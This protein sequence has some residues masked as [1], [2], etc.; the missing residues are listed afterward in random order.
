MDPA[1]RGAAVPKRGHGRGFGL[2]AS[3]TVVSSARWARTPFLAT[4]YAS[5]S[6]LQHDATPA[7]SYDEAFLAAQQKPETS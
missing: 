7:T 3:G 6:D 4:Q 2:P 1:W 5:S